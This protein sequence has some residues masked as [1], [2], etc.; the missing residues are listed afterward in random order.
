MLAV[1]QGL[2]EN[3]G[4]VLVISHVQNHLMMWSLARVCVC[5]CVCVCVWPQFSQLYQCSWPEVLTVS[6]IK[7]HL[8]PTSENTTAKCFHQV[9]F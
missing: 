2:T 8:I 4:R 9:K 7:H 5:V 1:F 6:V 3:L